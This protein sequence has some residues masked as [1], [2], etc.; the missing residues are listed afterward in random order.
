MP[1]TFPTG[2]APAP[3]DTRSNAGSAAAYTKDGEFGAAV[4]DCKE[5]LRINPAYAKAFGRL[6]AAYVG[7]KDTP[8]A[9]E[10]YNQHLE[11]EPSNAATKAALEALLRTT[12]AG[13]RSPKPAGSPAFGGMPGGMDFAAMMNNPQMM[14]MAK[15]MMSSGALDG[16]MNNP[17]MMG[18]MQSMMGGGA[19]MATAAGEAEEEHSGDEQ[20]R[21]KYFGDEQ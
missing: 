5:A 21:G 7:L 9:V 1:S 10:A 11:L 12:S 16:I 19:P 17:Q 14:E 6:G 4:K 15:N 8:K 3:R 20:P 13:S 2:T 18:M